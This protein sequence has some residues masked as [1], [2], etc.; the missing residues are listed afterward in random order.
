MIEMK[1]GGQFSHHSVAKMCTMISHNRSRNTNPCNFVIEQKQSHSL[2]VV[3]IS[4]LRLHPLSEII[5][6]H[7]DVV[8][9]DGRRRVVH[10]KSIPHLAKGLTETTGWSGTG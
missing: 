2:C 9:I 5:N 4:R 1:H 8:M 3:R 6:E 10:I 7:D